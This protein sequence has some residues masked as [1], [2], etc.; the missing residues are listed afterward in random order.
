MGGRRRRSRRRPGEWTGLGWWFSSGRIFLTTQNVRFEGGLNAW[1][2]DIR[3]SRE[4]CV[5]AKL[6]YVQVI[7]P[8]RD[9]AA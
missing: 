7:C 2:W 3:A 4:G 5:F 8:Q 6:R 1:D 9:I